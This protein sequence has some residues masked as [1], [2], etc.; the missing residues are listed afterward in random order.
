MIPFHIVEWDD[1][2]DPAG[3]VRHIAA[4]GLSIDDVEDVFYSTTATDGFSR[5]SG[6]PMRFGRTTTGKFIAVVYKVKQGRTVTTIYPVTA[7]E[8]DPH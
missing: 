4:H 1:P 2:S 6:R 5:S 8:V 3:N 7:Y